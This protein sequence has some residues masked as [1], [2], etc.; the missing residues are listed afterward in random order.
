MFGRL[1]GG[2]ITLGDRNRAP[3]LPMV[4]SVTVNLSHDSLLFTGDLPLDEDEELR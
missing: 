4:V 1:I 2:V 3:S